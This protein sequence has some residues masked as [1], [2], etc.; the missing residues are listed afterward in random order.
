MKNFIFISLFFIGF[1][2]CSDTNIENSES[3]KIVPS[4]VLPSATGAVDDVMFV[5]GNNQLTD[6]NKAMI[7]DLF[8]DSYDLLPQV[9]NRFN[10][11]K[12]KYEQLNDILYRF[13]NTAFVSS[14]DAQ[15]NMG[16]FV[17][18]LLTE[19]EI[20]Q[21]EA[22][23]KNIFYKRN[24]WSKP[25]MIMI[26]AAQT[27]E[28]I[29]PLLTEKA[30]FMM[31]VISYANIGAYKDLAYIKG[32]NEALNNQ[33]AEY[34]DLKFDIPADYVIVENEGS[35]LWLR[36]DDEKNVYNIFFDVE[37]YNGTPAVQNLGIEKRNSLGG[38]VQSS[39]EEA[40]MITDTTLGTI[41]ERVENDFGWEIYQNRGLWRME[42]DF[43]GGPFINQ[44]IIDQENNRAIYIEGFLFGPDEKKKRNKMRQFEAIF[45]TLEPSND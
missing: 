3:D 40:Y 38:Y 37:Y 28:D 22:G 20:A 14:I 9:E 21:A 5:F 13:R 34:H 8:L 25:Q 27:K 16:V 45:S 6:A 35:F 7:N 44:Y 42:N 33:F 24:I 36:K 4:S 31:D 1:I 19:E 23:E 43:F 41:E 2:A 15:D 39:I 18:Q 32:V 10:L 26:V 12:I 29:A 17:R 30:D 11:S